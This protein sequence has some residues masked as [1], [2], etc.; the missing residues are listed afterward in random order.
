MLSVAMVVGSLLV[1][2]VG[3]AVLANG[4]VRMAGIEHKLTLEQSVHHQIELQVAQ[5][6]T[7]SRI[8]SAAL[9]QAHMVHPASV[10]TLPYVSL[11][12]PLPTPTVTPIPAPA[13]TTPTTSTATTT[14]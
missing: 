13:T 7:P 11:T 9:G 1:V 10:I 4:Q 8:V 5:G 3:H 2:V 12:T 6:Q 14:P